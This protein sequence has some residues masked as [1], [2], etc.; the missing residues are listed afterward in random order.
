MNLDGSCEDKEVGL[1]GLHIVQKTPTRPQWIWSS[2]E[3]VDNVPPA[4]SGSPATPTFG[5]NDGT[6][7]PMPARDPNVGFPP[8]NWDNPII[9]NVTR[10]KPIH[11]STKE[12]NEKYRQALRGVWR[13][14][15]L[16]L[17]QW[18]LSPSGAPANSPVP[19]QQPGTPAFTFP[20][21][22]ATSS[23]ANTVLETWEQQRI[24]TGC[25]ACHNIT[26]QGTPSTDFI[27][28][29]QTRALTPNAATLQ[30]KTK[31]SSNLRKLMQVLQAAQ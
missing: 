27:W 9:Y 30:L 16:V 10:S 19:P 7:G 26:L 15:Q 5:F 11:D 21:T 20:G 13:N 18:P 3:H 22:N 29:V 25:M 2:F 23:F 31:Q 24:S 1:V 8:T 12:T 4:A 17:T 28:S 6:T 14:Y